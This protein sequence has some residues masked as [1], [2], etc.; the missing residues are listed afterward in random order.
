MNTIK[1]L[2]YGR[3][4][5]ISK[6]WFKIG[7]TGAGAAVITCNYIS[8]YVIICLIMIFNYISLKSKINVVKLPALISQYE[9]SQLLIFM[10]TYIRV[11]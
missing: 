10:I 4:G 11:A 3:S 2:Q 9:Y 6:Y 7:K 1:T 8:L 5:S